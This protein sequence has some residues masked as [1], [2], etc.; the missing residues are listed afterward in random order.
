[1]KKLEKFERELEKIGGNIILACTPGHSNY[2]E[3][4]LEKV[5][6]INLFLDLD[7]F[8]LH[9]IKKIKE[10]MKKIYSEYNIIFS[11]QR[12]GA[13]EYFDCKNFTSKNL[14]V[15]INI[16][17]NSANKGLWESSQLINRKVISGKD[18]VFD[19]VNR[20]YDWSTFFH[21]EGYVHISIN[22]CFMKEG[23]SEKSKIGMLKSS[24]LSGLVAGIY[25]KGRIPNN[26]AKINHFIK[27]KFG[28]KKMISILD[29]VYENK[30]DKID[31]F[32]KD[33]LYFMNK[34]GNWNG[35]C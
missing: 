29:K 15:Y 9:N 3:E 35:F 7:N 22:Y 11:I 26:R 34:F 17:S 27:E 13:I 30:Y 28:D 5:W 2:F 25:A 14:L 20:S 33:L 4:F 10:V 31:F 32:V 19:F 24:F 21:S 23:L 8:K 12:H 1:M 6:R 18:F 16:V